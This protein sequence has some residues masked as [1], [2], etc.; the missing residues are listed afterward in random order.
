MKSDE[1]TPSPSICTI[2]W[3]LSPI[4]NED[5]DESPY[6]EVVTLNGS[7]R[8]IPVKIQYVSNIINFY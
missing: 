3:P 4:I 8:V 1:L 7:L 6:Y 5:I 2:L